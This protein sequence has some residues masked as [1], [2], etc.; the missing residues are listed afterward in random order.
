MYYTIAF[1]SLCL[2]A[3][4]VG[5]EN[6]DPVVVVTKIAEDGNIEDLGFQQEAQL[7]ITKLNT[8]MLRLTGWNCFELNKKFLLT[9]LGAMATYAI[10]I[11]QMA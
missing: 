9:I 1:I 2:V 6:S 5:E 4:E 3:S 11:L 8:R 10:I 7:L